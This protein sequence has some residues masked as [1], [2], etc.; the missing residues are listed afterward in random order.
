LGRIR[1]GK[2]SSLSRIGPPWI[3]GSSSDAIVDGIPQ[4][5][6]AA[7]VAFR[8][9]YA[10]VPEQELYLLEFSSCLVTKIGQLQYRFGSAFR[11]F[12]I[13]AVFVF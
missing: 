6:F 13:P 3:S 4:S 1:N 10:D 11:F 12:A 7:Q 9:L 8:C 5:L 2:S